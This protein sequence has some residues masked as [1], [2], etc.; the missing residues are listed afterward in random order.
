MEQGSLR[1]DSTT[2]NTGG[3]KK[4]D[5][6]CKISKTMNKRLPLYIP[7]FL[8][9]FMFFACG[10]SSH[11]VRTNDSD[12]EEDFDFLDFENLA[13]PESNLP[14]S[15][16]N[17][18]WAYI[19]SG[20]E[21]ALKINLPVSDLVYFGA[22][23]NRYGRL[24]GIPKRSG[25]KKFTGRVHCSITCPG[26]GLTHFVIEPG[27]KARG[28]LIMEIIKAAEAYEG[29]NIDMENVPV[30]DADNFLSFLDELNRKLKKTN[31]GKLFSVCVPARTKSDSTYNYENIAAHCDRVFVMAY[32]EH[33]STSRPG[34]VASMKWCKDVAKYS[35]QT[36]GR[37]KLIMGV[38][39][40]GRAWGDTNVSRALINS[41]TEKL[42][43]QHKVEDIRRVGGI[44]T[45]TY[46]VLVKVTVYYEDEI[47]LATRIDM[48]R[49]QGVRSVGFWCL[50]Q[51]TLKIWQLLSL[52]TNIARLDN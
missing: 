26:Y 7:L 46:E 13:F 43:R 51:E 12:M 2:D 1:T 38:P 30:Q 36:I 10:T 35:L 17:E 8:L 20:N 22:E 18:I 14:V 11:S 34:P 37:D 28:T 52:E 27:S 23:V 31:A 50:G 9:L 4:P 6:I 49:K 3:L 40:Y 16:F 48:Y 39:F 44:P 15:V 29:L 25:L 47:S 21:K 24:T 42:K 5:F 19:V 41:T 45:F 33:W 32:D